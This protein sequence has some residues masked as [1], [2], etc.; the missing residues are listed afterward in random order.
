M[1]DSSIWGPG[2]PG[3]A[4]PPG[5]P[6]VSPLLRVFGGYIQYSYSEVGPWVN[7]IA[8]A[9]L[10]GPP[11]VGIQGPSGPP[12]ESIQGDPGIQGIP[13]NTGPAGSPGSVIHT[14]SG[15]PD[16]SL[17]IDGDYY[18]D[19]DTAFL[20]GPKEAG[21]W[22]TEI[23]DLRG[24]AS[25]VNYGQRAVSVNTS[26]IAKTAATDPT[27]ATNT[28]YTQ[29]TAIFNATPDGVN[30]GITQQANSLTIA[31]A[32]TYEITFWGCV[33]SNSNNTVVGFK[34]AVNGSITLN[35][36]PRVRVRN[37]G[38]VVPVSAN[39]FITLAVGDIVSLWMASDTTANITIQDAVFALK[40]LR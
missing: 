19:Q 36:R 29:V 28:D 40:E 13:G 7:L 34:F 24:G 37:A 26:A 5:P 17:G 23:L 15:E 30:R 33:T 25:G 10:I 32:G 16:P 31:R 3:P 9:D 1:P 39:G 18:I 27:L 38:E 22:F 8:T 14:D 20:Y 11:G 12:G 6:G 21:N 4:G 2:L 35:R